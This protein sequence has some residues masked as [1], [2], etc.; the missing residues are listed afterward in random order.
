LAKPAYLNFFKILPPNNK[1]YAMMDLKIQPHGEGPSHREYRTKMTSRIY[2]A[3]ILFGIQESKSNS[4][5][6]G[7]S[8]G[9]SGGHN[10]GGGGG[11]GGGSRGGNGGGSGG[12]HGSGGSGGGYG[13]GGSGGGHGG[14]GSG[15]GNGGAMVAAMAV[16]T[17]AAATDVRQMS[18]I[19]D[20]FGQLGQYLTKAKG[21]I[22]L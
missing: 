16:A 21:M 13:G 6:G 17:A 2:S 15:G 11:N 3:S 5:S 7:G 22:L 8:C 14:G 9:C 12:G 10:G 1:V 20:I 18:E 19:L 4:D